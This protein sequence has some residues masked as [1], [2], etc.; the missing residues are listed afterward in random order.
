MAKKTKLDPLAVTVA[1][2]ASTLA[3]P[4]AAVQ[5]DVLTNDDG[6]TVIRWLEQCFDDESHAD[7]WWITQ[8]AD[9]RTVD[10]DH[11]T[12]TP[13]YTDRVLDTL[14]YVL[15]YQTGVNVNYCNKVSP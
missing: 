1:H 12:A 10:V 14:K 13:S 3:I 6:S 2:P 9:R 5:A 4:S 8:S 15:Q 11:F 7:L